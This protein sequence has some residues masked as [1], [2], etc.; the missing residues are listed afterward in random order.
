MCFKRERRRRLC[1]LPWTAGLKTEKDL[2]RTPEHSQRET[3]LASLICSLCVMHMTDIVG[4]KRLLLL[5]FTS[6][7]KCLAKSKNV[8][9][10]NNTDMFVKLR[11]FSRLVELI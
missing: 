10:I 11:C 9:S 6:Q 1:E 5:L 8:T 3:H 2:S 4:G 7:E